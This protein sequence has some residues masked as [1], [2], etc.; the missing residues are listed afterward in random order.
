MFEGRVAFAIIAVAAAVPGGWA[1]AQGDDEESIP[2]GYERVDV[3]DITLTLRDDRFTTISVDDADPR[4]AY[5]GSHQGRF[6]KTTDRGLTWTESTIITEKGLL[7]ATPESSVFFGAIRSAGTSS[8]PID[9]ISARSSPIDLSRVPGQLPRLPGLMAPEDPLAGESTIS[10]L[11]GVSALGVGLSARSPRLSLLTASRG[12]GV[13]SL[14]RTKLLADRSFRGTTIFGITVHP[15]DHQLLFAVTANGLYKSH[16]GGESWTRSFAGV[17]TRIAIR[18]GT[19]KLMVLGTTDGA[20]TSVDDGESWSK[21]T[22]VGGVVTDVVFDLQDR[23]FV[24]LGTNGG[25]MRSSDGGR[26]FEPIYYTTFPAE[27][28]VKTMALDPFDPETLYIGTARGA[29]VTHKLRTATLA[30]WEQLGGAQIL[31]VAGIAACSKHQGHLYSL[32]RADLHTINYGASPPESSL[33]ESWNGGRTWRQL[34]TGHSDGKAE[35]FAMDAK[36]PDQVWVA[37]TSA[38]HRL[39]RAFS[40]EV[41][42]RRARD[43]AFGPEL[44]EV[45]LATLQHHGL[46]LAEYTRKIRRDKRWMFLPRVV[47]VTGTAQ[48]W[49]LGGIQD[50]VQFAPD[51]YFQIADAREWQVMAWASWNLPDFVY[52]KDEVPMLRQRVSILNDEL[53]RRLVETVR[54]SYGEL[55]RIQAQLAEGKHDLKTRVIYRLRVEQLEAVVDLASGGYLTRWRTRYRRNAK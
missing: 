8:S 7:W 36:D 20:H 50:D 23:N 13:P 40:T 4:I 12:R 35:T 33:M 18:P 6:Y 32:V 22:T 15:K 2:E 55:L 29:Y 27:A 54:R 37:W 52:S 1:H 24:Y 43:E 30:D 21:L 44:G 17:T 38:V 5:L 49:S 3:T 42:E 9:L 48:Q 41:A 14:N 25:V 47:T 45:V 16:N 51:R 26:R 10:A 28:D 11:G 53:R 19:P 31:T 34:F 46:E 39:S